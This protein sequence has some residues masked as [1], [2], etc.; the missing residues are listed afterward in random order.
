[1]GISVRCLRDK[2]REFKR[3]GLIVP[4]PHSSL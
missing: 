4:E 2:I 1:L 3:Q